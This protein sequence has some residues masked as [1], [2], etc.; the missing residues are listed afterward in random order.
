MQEVPPLVITDSISTSTVELSK[1]FSTTDSGT[2][3]KGLG[4][5]CNKCE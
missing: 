1:G 4:I 3:G 2:T 5:S